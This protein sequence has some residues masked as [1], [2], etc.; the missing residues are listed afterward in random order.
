M[1]GVLPGRANEIWNVRE[2][3]YAELCRAGYPPDVAVHLAEREDI[4]LHVAIDL[5]KNGATLA[6]AISILL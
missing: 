4:D 2:W 1:P 5:L 6:E 3:R